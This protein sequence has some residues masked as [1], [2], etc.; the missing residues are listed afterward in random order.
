MKI[1]EAVQ[2][3]IAIWKNP[4]INKV[5]LSKFKHKLPPNWLSNPKYDLRLNVI[6][7]EIYNI[8]IA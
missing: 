3:L 4:G 1:V 5:D 7:S 8:V 6:I 2:K